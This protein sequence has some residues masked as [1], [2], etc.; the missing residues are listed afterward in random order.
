VDLEE[1]ILMT[2]TLVLKE[3]FITK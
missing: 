3:F 1:I 2:H